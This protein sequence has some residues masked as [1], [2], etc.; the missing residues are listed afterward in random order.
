MMI[1]ASRT[2]LMSTVA[3]IPL[4]HTIAWAMISRRQRRHTQ[5]ATTSLRLRL[6]RPI[7]RETPTP[8]NMRVPTILILSTILPTTL[9][10]ARMPPTRRL[11][12]RTVR[13][14]PLWVRLTRT[15]R[16]RAMRGIPLTTRQRHEDAQTAGAEAE[17]EI[18]V[19]E[20]PTM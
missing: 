6:T 7:H 12:A 10:K 1:T 19:A 5:A 20:I 3:I 4:R 2:R 13:A 15:T 17:A 14:T 9:R 11:A 16:L 8:S 18:A